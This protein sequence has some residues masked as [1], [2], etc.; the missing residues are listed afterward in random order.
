MRKKAG[1]GVSDDGDDGDEVM[2]IMTTDD[3]IW[4]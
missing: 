4:R 2:L 1:K 3:V